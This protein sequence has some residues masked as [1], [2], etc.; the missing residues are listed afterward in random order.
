MVLTDSQHTFKKKNKRRRRGK[1]RYG[2]H[3]KNITVLPS[4]DSAVARQKR[5]LKASPVGNL[6]PI[7]D[8]C[9]TNSLMGG[10]C[11]DPR[12]RHLLMG[13]MRIHPHLSDSLMCRMGITP[14]LSD[15][16]MGRMRRFSYATVPWQVQY[17]YLFIY[18]LETQQQFQWDSRLQLLFFMKSKDS[19]A[20]F[21][22][23]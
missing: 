18:V 10:M 3:S 7:I 17:F 21:L 2:T 16:L 19:N 8:S 12:P 4:A 14:H 15:W 11:I 23:K 9:L 20:E 6:P 1:C 5:Q 13:R 22:R